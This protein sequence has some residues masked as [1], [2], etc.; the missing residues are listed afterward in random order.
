MRGPLKL[1]KFLRDTASLDKNY[2]EAIQKRF[3]LSNYQML[4]L[5]WSIGLSM[6]FGSALLL[7]FIIY[8]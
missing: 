8:K 3:S 5:S 7:H 6:G 4:V 1:R 2:A